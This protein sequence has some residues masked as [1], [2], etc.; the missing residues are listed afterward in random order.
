MAENAFKADW[1]SFALGFNTG[2]SKGGGGVELNIAYGDTPPEDTTKLWVKTSEPSGVTMSTDFEK[3]T[4]VNPSLTKSVSLPADKNHTRA[5]VAVVDG[6]V[7]IFG[8]GKAVGSSN[9][10]TTKEIECYDPATKTFTT[11]DVSMPE[12]IYGM[13]CVAVGRV[14]YLFGGSAAR[15]GTSSYRST[16]YRFDV[17]TQTFT[18]LSAHLSYGNA[19]LDAV[20]VETNIY[21]FDLGYNQYISDKIYCFDTITETISEYSLKMPG[22]YSGGTALTDGR[23]IYYYGGTFDNIASSG[24]LKIDVRTNTI[25]QM[26][27]TSPI[28]VS[29]I[30]MAGS[31]IV[32]LGTLNKES[33]TG[34]CVF[35]TA[36]MITETYTLQSLYGGTINALTYANLVAI[37]DDVHFVFGDNGNSVSLPNVFI[38]KTPSFRRILP[39]G[40]IQI[41]PSISGNKFMMVNRESIQ[42]EMGVGMVLKGN[43][44][45]AAEPVEAALYKDG[46]WATI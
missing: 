30:V 33:V 36:T 37:G 15:T 5:G 38:F 21:I 41:D 17:D 46:K 28:S 26:N 11:L 18:T 31:K 25:T 8:G 12:A 42:I 19:K 9:S 43:E 2:K 20:L 6:L 32:V 1:P 35:D 16:I 34:F 45:D 22:V 7:Y 13:A 14:V 24:I 29:R 10:T 4:L 44:N 39:H 23:Y 40:H 27:F 3:E